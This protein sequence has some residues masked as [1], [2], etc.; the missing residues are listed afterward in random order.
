MATAE[1]LKKVWDF[2]RRNYS[3]IIV[4]GGI[5]FIFFYFFRPGLILSL[6]T[7]TGGDMGSHYYN[8]FYSSKAFLQ[9]PGV[10]NWDFNW[11]AGYPP[12]IFYMPLAFVLIVILNII[13]PLQ[14]AFKLIVVLG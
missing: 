12:F 10:F 7:P 9:N 2:I 6:A 14:I 1:F 13:L 5:Y 11:N 3:S 8:A 4:F